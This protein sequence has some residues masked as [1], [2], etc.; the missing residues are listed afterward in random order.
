[1]KLHKEHGLNPA[2]ETCWFCGEPKGV[3]LF[4]AALKDCAPREACVNKEPCDKCK[5]WMSRGVILL[6][7]RDDDKEYRTGKMAVVKDVAISRMIT[8]EKL[9]AQVLKKRVCLIA[10]SAWRHLGLEEVIK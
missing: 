1:M 5:E 4:G 3:V 2:L 7:V 6:S 8:D 10:D 9:R